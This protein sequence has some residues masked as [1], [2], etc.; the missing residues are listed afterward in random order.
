ML[1]NMLG[2]FNAYMTYNPFLLPRTGLSGVTHLRHREVFFLPS[3]AGLFI[4][5]ARFCVLEDWDMVLLISLVPVFF[6]AVN[7]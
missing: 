5:S 1:I 7:S 6:I 3:F 2:A 4:F